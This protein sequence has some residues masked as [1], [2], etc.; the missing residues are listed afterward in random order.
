MKIE[1]ER[2][3]LVGVGR[4]LL[5]S[6]TVSDLRKFLKERFVE[7]VFAT[8]ENGR[9]VVYDNRETDVKLGDFGEYPM[10]I[11]GGCPN[12]ATDITNCYTWVSGN[13]SILGKTLLINSMTDEEIVS[14]ARFDKNVML[15]HIVEK[16]GKYIAFESYESLST[17][18]NILITLKGLASDKCVA[19][20]YSLKVAKLNAEYL[21]VCKEFE[22]LAEKKQRLYAELKNAERQ[23]K[24]SK[25]IFKK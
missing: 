19:T 13:D 18:Y 1:D 24:E 16:F 12:G 17:P 7:I 22:K 25:R 9:G 20:D 15:T 6:V 10:Y 2:Y 3:N 14:F 5:L 23:E 21:K 11:I 8:S 4:D